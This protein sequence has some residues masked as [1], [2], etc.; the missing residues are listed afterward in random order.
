MAGARQA[1]PLQCAP[2]PSG[3]SRPDAVP[4][5]MEPALET[6]LIGAHHE[7][8]RGFASTH[9]AG[10]PCRGRDRCIIASWQDRWLAPCERLLIETEIGV[11]AVP[12]RPLCPC[13]DLDEKLHG[14]LPF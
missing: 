5:S 4:G 3:S 2:L 11:G 9:F 6:L 1:L 14:S 8:H 10:R 13:P 12:R 7:R